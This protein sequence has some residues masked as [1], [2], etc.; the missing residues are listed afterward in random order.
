MRG[1]CS[2]N[3]FV[4]PIENTL[5]KPEYPDAPDQGALLAAA[6]KGFAQNLPKPGDK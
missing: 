6:C 3:T 1:G 4:E 2:T 5:N